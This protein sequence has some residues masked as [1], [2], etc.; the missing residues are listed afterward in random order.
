[1]RLPSSTSTPDPEKS[2]LDKRLDADAVM[3]LT[4]QENEAGQIAQRVDQGHD[5]GRQAAARSADGLI[6]RP[7]FAPVPCWWTRTIVPS[8]MA[9]SKSGSPDKLLKIL[10]NTPFI[11]HLRKRLKTEFQCPN[12]ACRSRH[13]D[14]VRAT[15]SIASKNSRLSAPVRPGSPGLPGS[16]G[17]T[18][19][20]CSS[21]KT[22]RSKAGLRFPTL[23]PISRP[24]GIPPVQ[25]NVNTP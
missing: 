8:M 11:A 18:R 17:A 14:P 9:Y 16:S 25:P 13:G 22:L 7:P 3:P 23:N 6:L 2:H 20:H 19:S 15:Q 1:M 4:G 12:A 10:S 24:S 21:L 5:L